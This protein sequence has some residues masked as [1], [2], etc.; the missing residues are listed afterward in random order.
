M[1]DN[2]IQLLENTYLEYGGSRY[3]YQHPANADWL[4]KV[5]KKDYQDKKSCFRRLKKFYPVFFLRLY[6]YETR[7]YIKNQLCYPESTQYFEEVI[8][9]CKTNL[10]FGL[11][12]KSGKE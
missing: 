8:G 11:I 9:F 7:E 2:I 5:I 4:I 3:V 12:V 10:G 1:G 6:Y